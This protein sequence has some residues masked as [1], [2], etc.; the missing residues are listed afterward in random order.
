MNWGAQM[1]QASIAT[2]KARLSEYLQAVKAGEEV[3]VTERGRP[4][5]RLG[6]IK[7]DARRDVHLN[8]LIRAGLVRPPIRK[9][10]RDFWDR[11]WPKDSEGRA[12]AAL[13]ED[14]EQ[15]R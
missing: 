9:L 11:P 3:I 5:A 10:P 15:G 1:K 2:L 8:R 7:V 13:L 14:R 6:P 4:V 12:L